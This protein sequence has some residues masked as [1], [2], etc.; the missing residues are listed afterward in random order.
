MTLT[1]GGTKKKTPAD[2]S[3]VTCF[4]YGGQGQ[5]AND[6]P[7]K[8][9]E[10]DD[11]TKKDATALITEGIAEGE[12]KEGDHMNF[13]DGVQFM[14]Q[15][16]VGTTM[17]TKSKGGRGPGSWILLDNQSTV[18][19]FHNAQLLT[20]LRKSDKSLD[21][22]RNAGVA[23]TN[24]VGVFLGYGTI[25]YYHPKGICQHLVSLSHARARVSC[26]V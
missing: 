4:N 12:F 25:W 15:H 19:I 10:K 1:Q 22:H 11:A 21:I 7:K 20:N 16:I 9:S 6:C 13:M 2:Q 14:Q 18:D 17:H 23:T 24:M 3:K 8:A 26:C 5:M